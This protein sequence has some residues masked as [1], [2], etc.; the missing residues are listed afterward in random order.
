MTKIT[1]FGIDL[2]INLHNLNYLIKGVP[3]TIVGNKVEL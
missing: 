2:G 1:K 3:N